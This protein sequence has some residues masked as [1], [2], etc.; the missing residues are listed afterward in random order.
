MRFLEARILVIRFGGVKLFIVKARKTFLIFFNNFRELRVIEQD[1]QTLITVLAPI[2][3]PGLAGSFNV[4]VRE[5]V[6]PSIPCDIHTFQA[7]SFGH[8]D[9]SP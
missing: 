2:K 9:T 4:A 5:G 6:E 8:S 7:C 1:A 3:K